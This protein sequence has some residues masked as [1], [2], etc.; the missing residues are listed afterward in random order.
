MMGVRTGRLLT[1]GLQI[2]QRRSLRALRDFIA[3]IN[4]KGPGPAEPIVTFEEALTVQ[5]I[6]VGM[7]DSAARGEEVRCD[8]RGGDTMT[9]AAGPAPGTTARR[10]HATRRKP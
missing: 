10:E 1:M 7:Y 3:A 9:N 6:L 8:I 2:R 4:G 5:R